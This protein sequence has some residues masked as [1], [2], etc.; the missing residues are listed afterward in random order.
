MWRRRAHGRDQRPRARHQADARARPRR[1]RSPGRPRSSATRSS[2]AADEIDLAVHRPPRN[3][4]RH[5]PEAEEI[6][7]L[8]EHLVLDDRRFDDRRRGAAC[9][10]RR[11][12]RHEV[13]RRRPS[14]AARAAASACSGVDVVERRGRTAHR[15]RANR[16]ARP[17]AEPP[18]IAR[19]QPPARLAAAGRRARASST[20]SVMQRLIAPRL[21][22]K[23]SRGSVLDRRDAACG[24][25]CS[26]VRPRA[27]NPR[28]PLALA[29]EFGGTVINADSMQVYRDLNVL[30]ARPGRGRGSARAA[31][32]LRRPRRRRALLGRRAGASWRA[33]EIEAARAAGRLPILVGG[34]GLYLRAL[35]ARPGAGAGHPARRCRAAA[36]A[37][38]RRTRRRR[39]SRAT[40]RARSRRGGALSR[41]RPQRLIRAYEV[42]RATGTPLAEW[43]RDASRS[44]APYRFAD[45]PA[46]AAAR[47]ALRRLRCALRGDDRRRG[48]LDEVAALMARGLSP[49]LPAMKAVGVPELLRHLRGEIAPRRGHCCGAA[50]DPALRQAPDDLV[51]PSA[52]ERGSDLTIAEQFSESL[53]PTASSSFYSIEFLLTRRTRRLAT[54]AASRRD[55]SVGA[56]AFRD[57][58]RCH[59]GRADAGSGNGHQGPGRSGR[60]CR[61]RLSRRRGPADLRRAVQAEPAAPHPGAPRAGARCT[62]PRAMRARPARSA[63]CW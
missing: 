7:Q 41:R 59:V 40:R 16:A 57:K 36:R 29:E 24:P 46:A 18:H 12:L 39:I 49:D 42:V 54:A 31:S 4:R 15:A 45:D 43:Q 25:I 38:H 27:A 20:H 5:A 34:T 30:T 37:L 51:P 63:S 13:D 26:P 35:R 32:A 50:G 22:P 21:A 56:L 52:A 3:R 19:A 1:A 60:R 14:I 61:F 8:V 58:E 10:A 6:G 23:A 62:R 48:A 9:A 47:G 28:W 53:L 2:S 55:P 11:R 44:A 17:I 33:G